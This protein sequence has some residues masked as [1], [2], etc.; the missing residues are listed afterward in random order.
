MIYIYEFLT[1]NLYSNKIAIEIV[2]KILYQNY[3]EKIKIN[4]K[5]KKNKDNKN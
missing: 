2:K 3:N 5:K 1:N 4:I